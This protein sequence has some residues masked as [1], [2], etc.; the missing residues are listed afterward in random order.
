MSKQN[1]AFVQPDLKSLRAKLLEKCHVLT[2]ST[3]SKKNSKKSLSSA[4][5]ESWAHSHHGSGL[6]NY[7]EYSKCGVRPVLPFPEHTGNALR[8]SDTYTTNIEISAKEVV[9]VN[10]SSES[11]LIQLLCSDDTLNNDMISIKDRHTPL[12]V[13]P[14]ATNMLL[15]QAMSWSDADIEREIAALQLMT[16][17]SFEAR[18]IK[19]R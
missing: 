10:Q 11:E 18:E 16:Q 13:N 7:S 9:P 6:E 4:A 5:P 1:A 8:S 14:D 19:V 17:N 3:G 15:E 2:S 12:N